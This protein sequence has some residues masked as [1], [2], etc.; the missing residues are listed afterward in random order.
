MNKPEITFHYLNNL[1][2]VSSYDGSTFNIDG[3]DFIEAVESCL[4]NHFYY[5]RL[6]FY[7][8]RLSNDLD[9]TF[10]QMWQSLRT[11]VYNH[12]YTHK[13][14]DKDDDI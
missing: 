4:R 12:Y 3:T 2:S 5:N 1:F 6:S 8:N 7:Y 13:D 9:A 11:Y 10:D 14:E